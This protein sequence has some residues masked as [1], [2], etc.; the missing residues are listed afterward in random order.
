MYPLN[1]TYYLLGRMAMQ[2]LLSIHL[3]KQ[4]QSKTKYSALLPLIEFLA[5]VCLALA[6]V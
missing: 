5:M 3:I 2:V 6:E 4:Q 1:C